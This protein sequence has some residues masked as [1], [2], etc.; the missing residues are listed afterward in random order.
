MRDAVSPSRACSF[1]LGRTREGR[2]RKSPRGKH[3]HRGCDQRSAIHLILTVAINAANHV[4]YLVETRLCCDNIYSVPGEAETKKAK[5][6]AK[7]HP[8]Q[9]RRLGFRR[10]RQLNK[11]KRPEPDYRAG[12]WPGQ[13]DMPVQEPSV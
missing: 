13:T 3:E 7:Q 4:P 2:K 10:R 12:H 11:I 8:S 9:L 1:R 5:P 6:Q